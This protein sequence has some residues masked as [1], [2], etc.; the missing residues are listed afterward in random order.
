ME[1]IK[2]KNELAF[3]YLDKWSKASWTKSY[4]SENIKVDNIT[5]N[6]YEA[7]N[8]KI[9]KYRSMANSEFM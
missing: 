7:F 5:N 6:N 3:K 2:R 9:L 1:V 4:F 8:A